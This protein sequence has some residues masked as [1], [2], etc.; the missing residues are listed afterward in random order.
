MAEHLRAEPGAPT[1]GAEAAVQVQ[2]AARAQAVQVVPPEVVGQVE[3]AR[4][5]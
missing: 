3:P 1:L 4:H 2:A 5:W